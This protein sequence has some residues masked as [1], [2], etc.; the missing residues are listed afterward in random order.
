M[1]PWSFHPSARADLFAAAEYY[2]RTSPALAA[3][4][5]TEMETL[6]SEVCADPGVFRP[7]H[8]ELCRHFRSTFPFAVIFVEEPERI[9]VLA[10]AHF[11][12]RP[13]YWLDRLAVP[14][15]PPT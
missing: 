12:R 2:E 11:K 15:P 1:K 6:C 4:F 5:V 13:G 9:Y 3:R 7:I 8:G 10:V 14:V